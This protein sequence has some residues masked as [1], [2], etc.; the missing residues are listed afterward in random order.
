VRRDTAVDVFVDSRLVESIDLRRERSLTVIGS[1]DDDMLVVDLSNGDPIPSG[2]IFYDGGG[3]VSSA[4][5]TLVLEGGFLPSLEYAATGPKAGVLRAEGRGDIRF[6]DLEP[7]SVTSSIG[8]LTINVTDGL[9][10]TVL[11]QDD[12]QTG[13]VAGRSETLIDGGLESVNFTNPTNSL[14]VNTGAGDDS[15]FLDAM[16]P[17]WAADIVIR[18]EAGDDL[19][20]LGATTAPTVEATGG[21]DQDLFVVFDTTGAVMVDGGAPSTVPGDTLSLPDG[22]F[23]GLSVP[24]D[25]VALPSAGTLDYVNIEL[26]DTDLDGLSDDDEIARGT[27]PND[28][29]TDGDGLTDGEEVSSVGTDPLDADSDDDGLD[30][31]TEVGTT[32]TD[33]LDADSDDD[34][35][36]D[37]A[38]VLTVGTDPLD[39]DTDD[40]GT[41]DGADVFPLD[42]NEQSDND[43]DG[44]GDNADPDDDNDG[45]SDLDELACGSDPL[46]A[47]SL[48]PDADGDD[49]P[50][51]VDT[52]DDNDGVDDA[53]DLCPE[54]VIPEPPPLSGQLGTNRWALRNSDGTFT[55]APPQAG[56]RRSFSTADTGGC[57]CGQIVDRLRGRALGHRK[58]GCSSGL[59]RR[60]VRRVQRDARAQAWAVGS[61]LSSRHGSARRPQAR[62]ERLATDQPPES[63]ACADATARPRPS[64]N[65]SRRERRCR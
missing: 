20:S 1:G 43:G 17:A 62:D 5:D 60:W 4:G 13:P 48:S 61:R 57:S 35:L 21:D 40:D 12:V 49:I 6:V 15:V 47:A 65:R 39:P 38:E 63:A 45:Q 54:T 41:E 52:D 29:D 58:R 8:A 34:G 46:D 36:G 42:P 18:G 51:C 64:R 28:P 53:A 33:P 25:T 3:E 27:A 24:A 26:V 44:I 55:Q 7:I 32:G 2:G 59:I 31:G 22:P 11:I 19:L 30:D 56:A 50:D 23:G 16:D 37:G 14:T 9:P 10:H